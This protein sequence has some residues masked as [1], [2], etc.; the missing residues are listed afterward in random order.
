MEIKT[1]SKQFE[2]EESCVEYLARRRCPN[3]PVCDKCGAIADAWKTAQPRVWACRSCH[4]A[5]SVTAGTPMERTHLPLPVWFMAIFLITTSSKG[6]PAMVISRQLGISYKSAWF[7]CHRIRQLMTDGDD[8][9]KGIV[10]VDETYIGGKRR[11]DQASRRDNDD[12]Q[13][14]GRGGSRKIMA[15]VGVE[16]DGKA[17]ARKGRTHSE[18]TIASAVYEWLDKDAVL[19]TDELPAYK[20]IGRRYPAH[21]RVNHSK[22]EWVRRDPLAITAACTNTAE[23]FN[24]TIKRAIVGVWHWISV[25]HVDHYLKELAIRWNMRKLTRA[26]RFDAVLGSLFGNTITWKGLTAK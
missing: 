4:K 25:K 15:V 7:M 1:F 11:R 9:L 8:T 26:E 14:K 24:A 16:R 2:T 13:P 6:V 17:K 19:A 10:E 23:S 22:G 21:V 12:D 18:R 20:W 3:G 5:F